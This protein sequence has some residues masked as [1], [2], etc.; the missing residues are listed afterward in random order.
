MEKFNEF[1]RRIRPELMERITR[2]MFKEQ[3]GVD[4][5]SCAAMTG[6]EAHEFVHN[7]PEFDEYYKRN[8]LEKMLFAMHET[9]NRIE[10]DLILIGADLVQLQKHQSYYQYLASLERVHFSE[11]RAALLIQAYEEDR[12]NG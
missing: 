7:D 12:K 4:L 10:E 6:E 11:E 9:F 3:F 5:D 8:G 1:Q 2:L